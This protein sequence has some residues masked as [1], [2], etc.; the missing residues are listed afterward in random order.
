MKSYVPADYPR[1]QLVRESYKILNGEWDFAFDDED[2]GLSKLWYKN[3]PEGKKIM[4]PFSY[5]TPA[6]GIGDTSRHDIVWYRRSFS[7]KESGKR[8][9]VHFEGCD[10]RTTVW[11]NGE[12]AG[13]HVGGYARFSFDISRFSRLT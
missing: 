10:F 3:F 7:A 4:V 13:S 8:T 6:S 5:E 2:A 11:I 12:H 1:P 9:F